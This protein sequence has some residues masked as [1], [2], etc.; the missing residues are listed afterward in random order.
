MP[1]LCG[2]DFSRTARAAVDAAIAVAHRGALPLT[3]LHATG[4][5]MQLATLPD[6][7][8][9]LRDTAHQRAHRQ[10]QL[11][12][13]VA[14][15]SARG[16]ATDGIVD[17]RSADVA[18]LERSAADDVPLV[19]VGAVG[20]SALERIL[21]G[22]TAERV[23]MAASKP[24]LVVRDGAPWRAWEDGQGPLRVALA[25]DAGASAH[26]AYAWGERL[27]ALGDVRLTAC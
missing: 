4:R 17:D 14:R 6:T 12:T 26:I 1:I 15:G 27:A 23:A 9:G 25:F 7:S 16:V 18:L 22:S 2:T 13:L 8:H 19:V 11:E 5:G 10:Q 24:V 20:H 21:L 3:L